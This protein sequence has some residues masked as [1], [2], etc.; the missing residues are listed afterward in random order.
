MLSVLVAGV[1]VASLSAQSMTPVGVTMRTA[2]AVCHSAEPAG[3]VSLPESRSAT[4]SVP[5]IVGG[6][7]VGG[8]VAVALFLRSTSHCDDC[9]FIGPGVVV[10]GAIGV[11]AG[12]LTGLFIHEVFFSFSTHR[13]N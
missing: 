4:S 13:G 11:A 9:F 7:L 5:F 1:P 12:A 2:G 6:A 10:S 8:A 3:V